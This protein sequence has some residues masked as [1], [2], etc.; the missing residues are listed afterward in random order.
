MAASGSIEPLVAERY[1]LD[2]ASMANERLE[3]GGHAGKVVLV[4]DAYRRGA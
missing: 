4:T 3:H 1:P 2:D